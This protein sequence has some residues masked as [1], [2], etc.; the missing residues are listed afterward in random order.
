MIRNPFLRTLT[1]V[2]LVCLFPPS[3]LD[4]VVN[5]KQ[6]MQQAASGPLPDPGLLLDLGIAVETIAPLLI[7]AEKRD[8]EAA[9][10]L[11]GFCAATALLYHQFWTYDDLMVKDQKSEGR[12]H[13]WE[14]LKN[15]GLVG[16]LMT[17]ALEHRPKPPKPAPPS[18]SRRVPI[19]ARPAP[20]ESQTRRSDFR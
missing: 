15:F 17:V 12:E 13:L 5:R 6:A 1:R 2:S 9:V 18:V 10:V 16:G 8:R 20:P 14:F 4:K 3:A 19:P 7:V 11:A